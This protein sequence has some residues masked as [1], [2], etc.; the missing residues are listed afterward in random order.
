MSSIY[1]PFIILISTFFSSITLNAQLTTSTALTP[2]QLVQ[3]VLLGPGIIASNITFNGYSNAIGWFHNGNSGVPGLGIDS[4]IVMT[5]GTVLANDPTY[6]V[7][8]GPQ[9]PNNSTGS[10]VDN[11]TPGD[12]YLTTIAGIGT[13]NAAILEFDFIAQA[14]SVKFNY[15]FGTEEYMEWITGGFAD[16]FAFVLNGVSTP[17][18]P[19][20]IALIPNTTIPVTALNVNANVNSQY[21]VN[22][23]NP[24]GTAAQYDGFTVVLT[25]KYPILC[26]ETYHIKLAVADAIDG[27]VDAGVF[28][29]AGS[30]TTG[31]VDLTSEISYGSSNDSTLY[32]GCGQACIS[33]VRQGG[34]T[35]ADTVA[36]VIGGTTTNG[37]DFTPQIPAQVIFQI[38]QDTIIICIQAIQD[39]IPEGLETLTITS[40]IN[41][42]CVQSVN[43]LTIYMSDFLPIIVNA[44]P[45]TSLCNATTFN[46]NALVSGGVEPYNYLWS[47]S[48]TSAGISVSPTVT[49]SYVVTVTDPC[50][51]PIGSD[52]V[53]IFLP[54]SNPL[55]TLPTPDLILCTGDPALV[56]IMASGGSLPYTYLWSTITGS[57]LVPNANANTNAFTPTT[58]GIFE[59]QT[60][61]GCNNLV[62]D[63]ITIEIHNCDII[64]PNIFTPNGDGANDN[65]VFFGLENF[66][67]TTLFIYNRWGNKIYES[68]NYQNDWNGSG[69]S[70]G[71]YYYLIT[72]MDGSTLT[73]FV[74]IVR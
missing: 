31:Q 61:D 50:G 35:L 64:P 42:P 28:L 70:D 74:T 9:G 57:D 46:L 22:N 8:M 39:L 6:G 56:G 2:A 63:T 52:T 73:G 33:I 37:I 16:V 14:D 71:T 29:Q 10:G 4:G 17:L 68:A 72:K 51:S 67:Q 66:P 13:N 60:L 5:T 27:I 53:T 44:G 36:L 55:A 40:T 43:S 26:G 65:L 34:L 19:I 62:L 21:Y 20:N 69:V 18:A 41:G 3:N 47:T 59:V 58:S 12:P 30:F 48:D 23:E 32:E 25:A 11:Q 24:P 45:D 54:S 49:T 15:V 7:G 1:F 38:G